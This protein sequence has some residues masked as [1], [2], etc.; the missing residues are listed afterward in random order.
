MHEMKELK[1]MLEDELKKIVKQ[2]KLST[3]TLELA[4]KITHAIKSIETIE[5]MRD[6]GYSNRSYGG[7]SYGYSNRYDR[8]YDGSYDDG[9]SHRIRQDGMRDQ[10]YNYSR[11]G[12]SNRDDYSRDY[13]REYSM[14]LKHD[15]EGLMHKVHGEGEQRMIKKWIKELDG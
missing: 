7:D 3:G 4:D 8:S 12:Y 5:A 13:S 2:G 9:Y 11:D 1:D 10:R 6:S 14:D 15:L